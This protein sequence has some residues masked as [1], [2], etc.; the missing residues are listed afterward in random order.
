L[1]LFTEESGLRFQN[2]GTQQFNE[3]FHFEVIF[4]HLMPTSNIT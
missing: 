2:M 3:K 1:N 4:S